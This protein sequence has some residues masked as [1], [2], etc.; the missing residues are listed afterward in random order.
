MN[1]LLNITK[2]ILN[3][4]NSNHNNNYNETFN[5]IKNKIETEQKIFKKPDAYKNINSNSLFLKN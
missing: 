1:Y 4:N 5:E 2:Y 3:M